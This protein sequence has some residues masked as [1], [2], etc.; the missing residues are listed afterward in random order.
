MRKKFTILFFL[1]EIFIIFLVVF[2]FSF[3]CTG[4][5]YSQN[6]ISVDSP[7]VKRGEKEAIVI[8]PGLETSKKGR[9]TLNKFFAH[10][11][12]DVFILDYIDKNSFQGTVQYVQRFFEENKLNEYK[13]LHIF[14][15]LLGSWAFNTYIKSHPLNN[16]ATIVYDRSPLQERAPKVAMLKHPFLARLAK[17]KVLADFEKIPYPSINKGNIK[18]GLLIESKA[19]WFI[20]LFKKATLS[21]GEVSWDAKDLK[22]EYDD[23]DYIWLDHDQMYTRVDVTSPEVLYFIKNKKFSEKSMRKPF[24]KDPFKKYKE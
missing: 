15:F 19:T 22:Q 18:I 16:I 4:I 8:L 7:S 5:S 21:L 14:S 17:G 12:Y 11:G 9:K 6:I 24:D 1:N 3:F 13:G 20:R 2:I 23:I 10:Q